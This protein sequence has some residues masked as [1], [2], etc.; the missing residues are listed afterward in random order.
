MAWS[1][2]AVCASSMSP[3]Q[4]C[5]DGTLSSSEDGLGRGPEDVQM[6]S[7]SGKKETD[8]AEDLLRD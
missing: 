3:R 8:A 7:I 6:H 5:R 1:L 4:I 2:D